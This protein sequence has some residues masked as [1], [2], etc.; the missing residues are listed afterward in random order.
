MFEFFFVLFDWGDD[1]IY[2]YA[3]VRREEPVVCYCERETALPAGIRYGPVVRD[4]YIIECCTEGY[5]SVIIN[6]K[7]FR[8]GPKSCYILLPGDT[9]IHTADEIQP[10]QGVWCA[11][12]GAAIGRCLNSAGISAE[13]PFAPPEAFEELYGWIDR[14]V[15]LWERKDAGTEL[16]LTSCIYGFM[17]TLLREKEVSSLGE[18]WLERTLGMVE[19]RYYEPLQVEDMAKEAG[20]ERAYFSVRFKAVMGESPHQYL[21]NLRIRKACG[22][23]EYSHYSISEVAGLV[24]MDMRNFARAFRKVTGKT[25]FAYRE[26]HHN[27]KRIESGQKDNIMTF[28]DGA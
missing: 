13:T 19:S 18:A 5:G 11:V 1:M 12:D 14:M 16:L 17:G 7:E 15:S 3:R 22:L 10:R 21:N 6:G 28:T 27:A 4:I 8:F 26:E 23:L 25:P 9:I 20:L 24:G 2:E